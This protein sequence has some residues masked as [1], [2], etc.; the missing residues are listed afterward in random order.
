MKHCYVGIA[1]ASL[2]CLLIPLAAVAADDDYLSILEAEAADTG[3]TFARF[4]FSRDGGL[5]PRGMANDGEVEDYQ[6]AVLDRLVGKGLV[7]DLPR[8]GAST[9]YYLNPTIIGFFE[10]TFMRER[11]DA[12]ME[13][14]AA[15]FEDVFEDEE[16]IRRV[17]AGSTQT[18]ARIVTFSHKSGCITPLFRRRAAWRRSSAG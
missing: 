13:E 4:R 11:P 2:A 14:Y 16:F 5:S 3:D 17:F 15:A 12:P 7:V 18:L 10:F 8:D 9:V 6:L 1:V